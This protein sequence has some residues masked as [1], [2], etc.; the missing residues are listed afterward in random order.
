MFCSPSFRVIEYP[1]SAQ[2]P[3]GAAVIE[4]SPVPRQNNE[5]SNTN[6]CKGGREEVG[7]SLNQ[8]VEL[9]TGAHAWHVAL[10]RQCESM[11]FPL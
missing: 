11:P 6:L 8:L 4:T 1:A 5:I 7:S 10:L 3:K 9:Q 2:D